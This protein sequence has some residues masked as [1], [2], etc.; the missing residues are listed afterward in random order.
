MTTNARTI[1]DGAMVAAELQTNAA[2]V[3]NHLLASSLEVD[4]VVFSSSSLCVTMTE[5]AAIGELLQCIVGPII[6]YDNIR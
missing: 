6:I 1:L 5:H 4:T 3:R 2:V